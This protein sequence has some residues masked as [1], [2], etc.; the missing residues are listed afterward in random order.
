[1]AP[2]IPEPSL[3][4]L[5]LLHGDA[6]KLLPKQTQPTHR[7]RYGTYFTLVRNA[8][9][10]KQREQDLDE[11]SPLVERQAN[12]TDF[13]SLSVL[14]REVEAELQRREVFSDEN[15]EERVV[16]HIRESLDISEISITSPDTDNTYWTRQR[17]VSA[18]DHLRDVVYGGVDGLAYVRSLAEFV[19][20]PSVR[21]RWPNA[22]IHCNADP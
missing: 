10:A 7:E 13:G 18:E 19:Q 9:R 12:M 6:T 11:P 5:H 20:S 1:M 2:L 14:S 17:A 15:P 4:R 22:L 8:P 16:N 21:V 3:S